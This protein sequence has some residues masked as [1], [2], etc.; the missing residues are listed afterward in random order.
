[1]PVANRQRLLYLLTRL[2]ERQRLLLGDQ[3]A[4]CREEERHDAGTDP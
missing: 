2:V 3:D 4:T 1:L